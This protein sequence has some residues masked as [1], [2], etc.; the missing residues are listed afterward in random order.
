MGGLDLRRIC[1]EASFTFV[2]SAEMYLADDYPKKACQYAMS[3]SRD[4][5]D[6]DLHFRLPNTHV[7]IQVIA[8]PGRFR[9]RRGGDAI[10][11]EEQVSLG[12]GD[13]TLFSREG[14]T[15]ACHVP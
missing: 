2:L 10:F 6:P 5:R 14:R 7:P 15:L 12:T 4:Q 13:T 11:G 1:P 9:A 3:I 8:Q